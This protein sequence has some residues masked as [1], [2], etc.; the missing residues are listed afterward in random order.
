MTIVVL[1]PVAQVYEELEAGGAFE[2]GGIPRSNLFLTVHDAILF[3]QHSSGG[4]RICLEV[5]LSSLIMSVILSAAK[6]K[7][8]EEVFKRWKSLSLIYHMLQAEV[9]L[10]TQLS[11]PD[12][13]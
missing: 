4:R 8:R 6:Q 7:D 10:P 3:A 11:H 2:D 1:P 12:V 13:V 9:M 5:G